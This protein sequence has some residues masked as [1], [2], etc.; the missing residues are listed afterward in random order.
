MFERFHRIEQTRGRTHEGTGI[1]LAL[2]NELVK[3]HGGTVSVDS[4]AGVGSTFTVA[5]PFG[6]AHL[7]PERIGK[8]SEPAST[9]VMPSAFIEE[10]LGWLPDEKLEGRR[11]RVNIPH[12]RSAF[13]AHV[14]NRHPLFHVHSVDNQSTILVGEAFSSRDSK[15]S[16]NA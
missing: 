4:V 2:V 10:A 1:G 3:L 12:Q 14:A 7:D 5:V 13:D 11:V 8:V 16:N 6:T 9:G 15:T